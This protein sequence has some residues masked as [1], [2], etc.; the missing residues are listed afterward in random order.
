MATT[1]I[2]N[3][4]LEQIVSGTMNLETTPAGSTPPYKVMLLGSGSNYTH[5]KT[6]VYLSD[7][8][9]AG[10]VEV[11]GSGYDAGG[12]TLGNITTSTDQSSNFVKV[13]IAD[14]Q[15]GLGAGGST[16]TAKGA[17]IYLPTGNPATSPLLAYINFDGTV[18]SSASVFTIDFQTPLKLQN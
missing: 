4:A 5:S 7:A 10:A 6:H 15:W 8:L 3:K 16:I 13:E 14:V 18:T 1:T 11:S 17:L 9:A 2:Y 12:K